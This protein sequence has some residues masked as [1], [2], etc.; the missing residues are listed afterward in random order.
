[1]RG[2]AT[3]LMMMGLWM[4]MAISANAAMYQYLED[5]HNVAYYSTP[6]A[7]LVIP[8]EFEGDPDIVYSNSAW[9]AIDST[10]CVGQDTP[11]VNSWG[12]WDESVHYWNWPGTEVENGR[13][14]GIYS[15]QLSWETAYDLTTLN[16][17]VSSGDTIGATDTDRIVS[18]VDFYVSYEPVGSDPVYSYVGSAVPGAT[19][20]VGGFDLTS[21]SGTWNGVTSVRY[22]FTQP[23]VNSA[24]CPRI[25]EVEAIAPSVTVNYAGPLEVNGMTLVGEG[26]YDTTGNLAAGA[27]AFSTPEIVDPD[28]ILGPT[29]WA[30][31]NVNDGVY[32][33]T[34]W[35]S[36]SASSTLGKGFVGLDLGDTAQEV[37][38]V[39]F[40]ENNLTGGN[41]ERCWGEYEIQY[42]TVANP[43][44][45]TPDS[46]WITIG[47]ADY[48]R[49]VRD[50]ETGYDNFQEPGKRHIFSFDS[51]MATGIRLIIPEVWEENSYDS[52]AFPN[53]GYSTTATSI[54]ELEV[55]APGKVFDTT[56]V[57]SLE[58]IAYT[59]DGV[60]IVS[61]GGAYTEDNLA[62]AEGAVAFGS[63][64]YG[65]GVHT[66]AHANDGLYG[67]SY[68]WISNFTAPGEQEFIGIALAEETEVGS[69][70]IGRN[71]EEDPTYYLDRWNGEYT[72]QYTNVAN[73]DATTS[74]E[75][76]TTIGTFEYLINLEAEGL[77]DFE[78]GEFYAA[79]LRHVIEFDPVTATALR[80]I[81][82]DPNMCIDEFEIYAAS[83]PKVAGDA[84]GDGKVDGSDVTILAGNWQKGVNDGLVASWEEGDFNGDG[85]VDGSDVTI[86]AGNWQYG[87]DSAAASVPE[88]STF[89][90]LLGV[91][92]SLAVI[93][94][95]K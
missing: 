50:G 46:A 9:P 94:R 86:L 43:D 25:A 92:A 13:P 40:S 14:D 3:F 66:I 45:N 71:S 42:T 64:E 75:D 39:A 2:K 85:K 55:Y 23:V 84:N 21:V 31:E 26:G 91:L 38:F 81:V 17:Y 74:D 72:L 27:T 48:N 51:V 35:I 62:L 37:G 36:Y 28:Y 6:Y 80:I 1:M 33:A 53:I 76:W 77:T 12:E 44:E 29:T 57:P 88:P 11:D 52:S 10:I 4:A 65:A 79:Y 20:D 58:G 18:N 47:T 83:S 95:V 67:N 22:D 78:D 90:L 34:D 59:T 5:P 61:E 15:L 54:D 30:A 73:P 93:R 7:E 60:A 32:K 19:D 24:Q 87:V 56:Y 49:M 68:S 41:L 70:A 89:V 63:S 82:S 8:G 16:A 69:I